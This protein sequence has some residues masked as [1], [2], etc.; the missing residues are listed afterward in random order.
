MKLQ[1]NLW[2]LDTKASSHMTSKRSYYHSIDEDQHGL[3]RFGD[4]SSIA[5]EGKGS[6]VVSYLDG[7]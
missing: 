4:E 2:Y 5:F 1:D 6:I 7:E 3:S